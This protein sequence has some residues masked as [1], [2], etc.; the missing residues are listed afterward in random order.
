MFLVQLLYTLLLNV[1]TLVSAAEHQME[2]VMYDKNSNFLKL[3]ADNGMQSG[4]IVN[5][6][7]CVDFNL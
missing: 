6:E 5:V 2:L 7:I 1:F 3:I 4:W